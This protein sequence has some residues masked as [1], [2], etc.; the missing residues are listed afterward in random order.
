MHN[1]RF[2]PG[3]NDTITIENTWYKEQEEDNGHVNTGV[4]FLAMI[5]FTKI[6]LILFM[7]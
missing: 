3:T 6:I 7:G 2:V 4:A 1:K 5:L